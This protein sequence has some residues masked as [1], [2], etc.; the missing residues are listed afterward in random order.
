MLGE[1][2]VEIGV[3]FEIVEV[4]P[5]N[6]D[7]EVAS[8]DGLD[9]QVDPLRALG[10]DD[11]VQG[12]NPDVALLEVGLLD[13]EGALVVAAVDQLQLP[14]EEL[15]GVVDVALVD[16]A[17]VDQLAGHLHPHVLHL[18][19][20]LHLHR[21]PVLDLQSYRQVDRLLL[22]RVEH[23]VQRHLALRRHSEPLQHLLTTHRVVEIQPP[24]VALLVLEL[25]EVVELQHVEAVR[26]VQLKLHWRL[27][28]V[29]EDQFLL[30]EGEG[31][32]QSEVQQL[33][34]EDEVRVGGL[35][36]YAEQL[37]GRVVEGGEKV[38]KLVVV[39]ETF[40]VEVNRDLP[41]AVGGKDSFGFEGSCIEA[42]ISLDLVDAE[43]ARH[44]GVVDE[45]DCF[46]HWG[47]LVDGRDY[48]AVDR[49]HLHIGKGRPGLYLDGKALD[50]LDAV[51]VAAHYVSR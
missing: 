38:S 48:P 13:E 7:V 27:L 32:E 18:A 29:L 21:P 47:V 35:A 23:A 19:Q 40:Q 44:G 28:R 25:V 20:H 12:L 2:E 36:L 15:V 50:G 42:S 26:V 8:L 6:P 45:S 41:F 10:P 11:A 17:Q 3:G 9:D 49:E 39:C 51:D 1:L 31:L 37:R 24:L 14:A 4:L 22:Q 34:F 5:L 43:G 33:F 46:L 16:L 30:V